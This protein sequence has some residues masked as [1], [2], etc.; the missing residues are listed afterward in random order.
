MAAIEIEQIFQGSRDLVFDAIR[1]YDLYPK[2]LPGVQKVEILSGQKPGVSQQVRYE[3]NIIKTFYYV[4][5]MRES[6]P[7]TIE[8]D[9][10]D[11]NIMKAN[12]GSWTFTA[13]GKNKTAAIY[14]LDVKFKGLVPSM[15]T[16]K[17]AA[18]N[19]PMMMA[20]FQKLIIDQ[21]SSD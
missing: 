10:D 21:K 18:A 13:A 15:I 1:R 11:S 14:R 7:S 8:W 9:L 17:I 3:L 19:L 5:N 16:D 4:L 12:S 20:G 6:S 2:Y